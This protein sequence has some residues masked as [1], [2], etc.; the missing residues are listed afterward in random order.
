MGAQRQ[1]ERAQEIESEALQRLD[2]SSDMP[3][4]VVSLVP[5]LPGQLSINSQVL[6]TFRQ[7][8]VSQP[9]PVVPPLTGARFN[10]ASV[11]RRRLLADDAVEG[12]LA[13]RLSLELHTD[14]SGVF[15]MSVPNL[16]R[17]RQVSPQGDEPSVRW[18]Q[19]ESLV[20]A[21]MSGLLLLAR[22]ARDQ[23]AAGGDALT[24][25]QIFPISEKQPTGLAQ[26]RFYGF[27]DPLGDR[28]LTMPPPPAE[29]TAELD[30]LAQPGRKLAA[31]TALLADDIAQEFGVPEMAQLSRDGQLRRR[32]WDYPQM[33]TWAEENG[34]AVIDDTIT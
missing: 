20:I 21:V 29:A 31:T 32:Y 1:A 9:M 24:R 16:A 12:P 8:I 19:D 13:K 34:L 23:A 10:R 4:V 28:V 7:R 5:D 17:L 22:D 26:T 25:A 6:N 27:L 15:G 33:I 2:T 30:D 11:G 18:I 14:G 3:W